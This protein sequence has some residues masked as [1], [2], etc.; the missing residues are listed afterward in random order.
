V[1]ET[2]GEVAHAA[3]QVE[4]CTS[5]ARCSG[6]KMTVKSLVQPAFAV[7]AVPVK[8]DENVAQ[9]KLNMESLT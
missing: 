2:Q 5:S 6:L 4:G 9:K 1:P 3:R 8:D 7:L